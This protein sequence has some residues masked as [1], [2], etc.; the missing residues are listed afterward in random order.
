MFSEGI[1]DV[2][3]NG[4]FERNESPGAYKL[5]LGHRF[6]PYMPAKKTC[7]YQED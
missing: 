2:I 4:C 5:F 1:A 7:L 3:T 6:F